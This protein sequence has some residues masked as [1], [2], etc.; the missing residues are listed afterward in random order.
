M[1]PRAEDVSLNSLK[2][3]SGIV[4]VSQE[5]SLLSHP[6]SSGEM[7]FETG[8]AAIVVLMYIGHTAHSGGCVK[9]VT[10]AFLKV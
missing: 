4:K 6:N 9:Y 2:S 8:P 3:T 10:R 1:I 5:I 7:K